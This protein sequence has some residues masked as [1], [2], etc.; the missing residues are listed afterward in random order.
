MKTDIYVVSHKDVAV[1]NAAIYQP[2]QV[3][4]NENNFSGFKR[5]NQ[6]DNMAAKNANYCE[7]T[8]QYWGWKNDAADVKGLVHYRR[9]FSNGKKHLFD[10]AE[11]KQADILDEEHL[12][13]LLSQ[14]DLILP[15]KRNYYI[16]TLWSHYEH[17]HHI[18]GLEVTRQVIKEFYPE[19]L[20]TFDDV[21]Q[22]KSAHMFNMLIAKDTV[23]SAYNAWLFDV[24][25]KVEDRIDI[26][27]YTPSEAR[28]FGYISELL[29]DVW[30]DQNKV[31]YAELPVMFMEKQNWIKKGGLFLKRKLL[32]K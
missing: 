6:G 3:G 27:N 21:M 16:E 11:K 14:Y 13:E 32:K 9:L 10:T 1:P 31:N 26:T 29:M 4:F 25:Q 15:T 30:V 28:I 8:A 22:R 5:D 7:L 18:E 19:Y 17:S 20:T 2:V 23:F 12:N 24:L